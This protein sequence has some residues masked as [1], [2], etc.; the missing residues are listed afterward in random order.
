M[1]Y[2]AVIIKLFHLNPQS[3]PFLS[4]SPPF[5]GGNWAVREGLHGAKCPAG[6]K[7][8]HDCISF[9]YF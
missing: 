5:R 4:D 7:P 6:V 1:L 9:L 8:R 3:L 2:F